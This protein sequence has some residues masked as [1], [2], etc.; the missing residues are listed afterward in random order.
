[1]GYANANASVPNIRGRFIAPYRWEPTSTGDEECT[2]RRGVG[3]LGYSLYKVYACI[4]FVW[5]KTLKIYG[6]DNN[7]VLCSDRPD[8]QSRKCHMKHITASQIRTEERSVHG[9]LL[10]LTRSTE[11]TTSL[12][13]QVAPNMRFDEDSR[14]A[15]S[16]TVCRGTDL[17][18]YR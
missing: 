9:A 1:M 7:N 8:P 12:K 17:P 6:S 4:F 2:V 15:Y 18:N 16:T 3:A 14:K 13:K 11:C 10:R 5:G